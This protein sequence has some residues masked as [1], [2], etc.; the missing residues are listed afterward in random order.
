MTGNTVNDLLSLVL[1]EV[2]VLVEDITDCVEGGLHALYE[3]LQE[4]EG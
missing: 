3:D 4:T 2:V 1:P